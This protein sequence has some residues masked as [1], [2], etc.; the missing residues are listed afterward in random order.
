MDFGGFKMHMCSNCNAIY[1]TMTRMNR[2]GSDCLI[3]CQQCDEFK[4]TG[5]SQM[6]S[7]KMGREGARPKPDAI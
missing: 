5:C 4:M 1:N 6:M 3:H 7:G 2:R